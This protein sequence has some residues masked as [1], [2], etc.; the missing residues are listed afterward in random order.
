VIHEAAGCEAVYLGCF[1][2]HSR[3]VGHL[4][5]RHARVAVIGAGSKGE[6][7]EEDQICCAWIAAG[8]MSKGYLAGSPQTTDV[9]RR[10]RDA[11][12]AACLCSQSVAFLRRTGQLSDLD[13]ILGHIDDLPGV[14][15]IRDGEVR[16]VPSSA[17]THR[18]REQRRLV[19]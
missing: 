15:E 18:R 16:M 3:L 4:A 17:R 1:R 9:V 7:R 12:P 2:S 6:F 13:F 8:L 19:K 11:P 5:R 10:W 14:F